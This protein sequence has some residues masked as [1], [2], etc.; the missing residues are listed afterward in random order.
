MA[1]VGVSE[2]LPRSFQ[3][4]SG[5]FVVGIQGYGP[6]EVRH[7]LGNPA[8]I[9]QGRAQAV[10]SG[11]VLGSYLQRE[12]VLPDGILRPTQLRERHAQS[13]QGRYILGIHGQ[14]LLVLFDRLVGTV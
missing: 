13:H 10:M 2:H 9:R 6:L 7:G 5:I 3:I 1:P 8:L 11:G 12:L 4:L 14:A